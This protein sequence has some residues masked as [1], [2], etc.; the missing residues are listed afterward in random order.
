MTMSC[1]MQLTRRDTILKYS[2][3]HLHEHY[4]NRLTR[5]GFTSAD[6]FSPSVLNN[7]ENKFNAVVSQ[8]GRKWIQNL[9]SMQRKEDLISVLLHF[10]IPVQRVLFMAKRIGNHS[11]QNPLERVMVDKGNNYVTEMDIY[12]G[13]RLQLFHKVW[14]ANECHPRVA[15]ILKYGYEITLK[16][17]IKL[18]RNPTIHSCYAN[19]QKQNFLLECVYQMLQKKA[20]IPV[21]MCASLHSRLFLVPK[22]GENGDQ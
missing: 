16:S 18:S 19:Q 7:V 11:L 22:P 14:L 6:V 12:P 9:F 10:Q 13:G 17:P 21:R 5:S 1:N 3:P 2:S 4:R 20:I 8:R 15:H